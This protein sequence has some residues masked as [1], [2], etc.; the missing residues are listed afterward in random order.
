MAEMTITE[1]L[2]SLPPAMF[3]AEFGVALSIHASGGKLGDYERG[4]MMKILGNCDLGYLEERLK[5]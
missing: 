3:V 1:Y 5:C 2:E 4:L